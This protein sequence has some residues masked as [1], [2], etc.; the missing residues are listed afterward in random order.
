MADIYRQELAIPEKRRVFGWLMLAGGALML[1][2]AIFLYY[3]EVLQIK[4]YES[5]PWENSIQTA[6]E[7]RNTD[8]NATTENLINKVR[9]LTWIV[10][11]LILLLIVFVVVA[12]INHRIAQHWHTTNERTKSVTTLIGDPW[13]EAGERFQINYEDQDHS[14]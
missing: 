12:A 4:K 2:I 5:R 8:D 14:R 11:I 9:P 7:A 1:L 13:K 3:T 6:S 10:L